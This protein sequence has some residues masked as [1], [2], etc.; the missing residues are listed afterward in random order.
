METN[1]KENFGVKKYFWREF[2]DDE[3]VSFFFTE[4]CFLTFIFIFPT[5]ETLIVIA[6][7]QRTDLQ[8][9]KWNCCWLKS[10]HSFERWNNN[11]SSAHVKICLR[12]E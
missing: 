6:A 7:R 4:K 1:L 11:C 8:R 2:Q 10:R 5:T 9:R 3:K 12:T